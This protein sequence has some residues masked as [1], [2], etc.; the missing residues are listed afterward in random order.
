MR[1]EKGTNLRIPGGILIAG[2]T[3]AITIGGVFAYFTDRE[4]KENTFTIGKISLDLTE[5]EWD[6][7]NGESMTPG[8]IL[9]KNPV[10]TNDGKNAE[11]VFLE[12]EVPI[13]NV[14]LADE[15]GE[16]L[17]AAQTELFTYDINQ[18]WTEWKAAEKDEQ[19]MIV[20]HYYVY[21]TKAKCEV[22][23]VGAK[24]PS[25]FDEIQ[26]VNLVEGQGLEE[27]NLI[28]PVKAYGIQT[29][30][31]LNGVSDPVQVWELLRPSN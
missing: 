9:P 20:R 4:V 27:Q 31:L 2:L 13:K 30:D 11:Y 3:A 5:T 10:V 19:A 18:G 28:V 14:V 25:L 23:N 22:L 1:K 7:T 21:G 24:T 17:P 29:E 15:N 6:E 16:K 12:V 26:L 8:K